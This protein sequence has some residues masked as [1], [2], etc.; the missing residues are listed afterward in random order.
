MVILLLIGLLFLPFLFFFGLS[1]MGLLLV[2]LLPFLLIAG[3]IWVAYKL[4]T[5]NR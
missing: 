3:G 1:I 5:R 4:A 2:K